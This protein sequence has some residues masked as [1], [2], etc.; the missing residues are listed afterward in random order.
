LNLFAVQMV[1][2]PVYSAIYVYLSDAFILSPKKT[3]QNF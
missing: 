2:Q 1:S 3:A